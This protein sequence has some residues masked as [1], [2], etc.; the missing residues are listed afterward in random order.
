MRNSGEAWW[1]AGK[2]EDGTNQ[3][4]YPV[5]ISVCRIS[6]VVPSDNPRSVR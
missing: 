4:R 6:R 3:S 5:A 2:A 1:E